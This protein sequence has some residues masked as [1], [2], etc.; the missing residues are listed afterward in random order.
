MAAPSGGKGGLNPQGLALDWMLQLQTQRME[1]NSG[2]ERDPRPIFAIAD[3]GVTGLGQLNANLVLS[4]RFRIHFEQCQVI[5]ASQRLI[6][7]SRQLRVRTHLA[8]G[9]HFSMP[10]VFA[11]VV[12]QNAASWRRRSFDHG[13][14]RLVDAAKPKRL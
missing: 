14:I 8:G 6:V 5:A 11:E 3:D 7:E 13:E 2:R 1:C 4:T 12:L 10:L 9:V